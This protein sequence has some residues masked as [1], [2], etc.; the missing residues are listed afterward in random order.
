MPHGCCRR[1][2][3]SWSWAAAAAASEREKE[4]GFGEAD[5]NQDLILKIEK[6]ACVR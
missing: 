1:G 2:T 6:L 5:G 4:R 3:R